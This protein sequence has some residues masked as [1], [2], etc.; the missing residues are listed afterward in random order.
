MGGT[1]AATDQTLE[2]RA[3]AAEAQELAVAAAYEPLGEL[4]RS[5]ADLV[6]MD[7]EAAGSGGCSTTFHGCLG[8]GVT[9]SI[10]VVP[11]VF[12]TGLLRQHPI[13]RKL[14]NA[15]R[16]VQ[17][18]SSRGSAAGTAANSAKAVERVY[19]RFETAC[20]D[21]DSGLFDLGEQHCYCCMQMQFGGA[22]NRNRVRVDG[23]LW[24]CS[25][26]RQL[27]ADRREFATIAR[28]NNRCPA[29]CPG[30]TARA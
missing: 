7:K 19:E 29:G 17:G 16:G 26:H 22:V 6:I 11:A 23:H 21:L 10:D 27:Q 25:C 1:E 15:G 8:A 13:C 5:S 12:R 4:L 2:A 20:D 30:C 9:I 28:P 18:N 3:A 24:C 14:F